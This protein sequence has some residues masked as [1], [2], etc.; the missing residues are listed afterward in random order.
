MTRAATRRS[1]TVPASVVIALCAAIAML[2]GYDIQA[3]GVAAPSMM[4]QLGLDHEQAG[5]ALSASMIGLVIGSLVGGRLADRIGRRPVLI[6][7][8]AAFGVFSLLTVAAET[9]ASLPPW[10]ASPWAWG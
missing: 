1:R 5:W 10:C 6:A 4:P 9:F 8:V 3:M 7:S 2:E